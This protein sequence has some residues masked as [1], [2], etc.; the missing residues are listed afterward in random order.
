VVHFAAFH[1]QGKVKMAIQW[2]THR[3]LQ[4]AIEKRFP[5]RHHYRDEVI[6]E[7]ATSLVT[8][9]P[10]LLTNLADSN[11]ESEDDVNRLAKDDSFW[12]IIEDSFEDADYAVTR[13]PD[14]E[15]VRSFV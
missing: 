2:E 10:K 1:K 14:D 9:Y 12:K 7:L 15:G 5:E 13:Y 6:L 8:A 3:L 4:K 11:M